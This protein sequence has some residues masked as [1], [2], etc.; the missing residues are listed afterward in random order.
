MAHRIPQAPEAESAVLG[1]VLLRNAAF[2]EEGVSELQPDDF[3]A[4][5]HRVVWEAIRTLTHGGHPI[6]IITLEQTLRASEKL[7]IVGGLE[8][9]GTLADR[10]AT[11]HNVSEHARIVAATARARRAQRILAEAADRAATIDVANVDDFIAET[12][13]ELARVESVAADGL[14]SFG[15]VVDAAV[16]V[17]KGRAS[18]EISPYT[19]G[20]RELDGLFD[21][22]MQPGRLV[23]VAGRPAMGKTVMGMQVAFESAKRGEVPLVFSLEMLKEQ[24]GQRAITTLGAISMK[25]VKDPRNEREWLRLAEARE[26]FARVGGQVWAR[27]IHLDKLVSVTRAWSRK[28]KK[29]GPVVVDYLTLIALMRR[30]F[31]STQERV[32]IITGTLKQLAMEVGVP[33]VLLAQLNRECE[34]REDKRPKLSDLRDSGSIEQDADAVVF[35][36]RDRVY[37]PQADA[38]AAEAILAKC[39]DGVVGTANIRFEGHF[40]RFVDSDAAN[41]PGWRCGQ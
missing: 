15:H 36:Y 6:D 1:A 25:D 26:F 5:K 39:R 10:Y 28:V 20:L 38:C 27:P 11:S 29:K 34:K 13:G 2:D 23:V 4:P 19:W 35:M 7:S 41:Q 3:H 12:Q 33:V 30:G 22:G 17:A 8:G 24:L 14:V 9:L 32:S 37:N 40:S 16:H 21:K 31:Y 18:G